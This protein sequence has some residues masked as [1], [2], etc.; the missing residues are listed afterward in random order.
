MAAT[1][2]VTGEVTSWTGNS[3]LV[4]GGVKPSQIAWNISA[5][6]ADVT[7]FESDTIA[8]EYIA[9]LRNATGTI[10]TYL[11]PATHGTEGLVTSSS[12]YVTGAKA[13]N[14]TIA[15]LEGEATAFS[16]SGVTERVYIP[17]PY[18]FSGQ[19]T[20][21]TDSSTAITL[22]ALAKETLTFKYRE[23]SVTDMSLAG[24]AFVSQVSSTSSPTAVAETTFAYRGSGQLTAAGEDASNT[25][26]FAAGA[27]GA[28]SA[29]TLTTVLTDGTAI[30][31]TAFPTSI[32]ITVDPNSPIQVVTGFRASGAITIS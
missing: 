7:A 12:N 1:F 3:G 16:G 19:Y 25:P 20:C 10:T 31:A 13:W 21:L 4:S 28:F 24:S 32:A 30:A 15:I 9:G 29:G 6:E 27:I 2:G 5:D 11:T 23:G 26:L 22:P 18:S 8:A 17:G 14:M